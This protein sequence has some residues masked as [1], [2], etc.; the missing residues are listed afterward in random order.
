MTT[1]K[2]QSKTSPRAAAEGFKRA[3]QETRPNTSHHQHKTFQHEDVKQATMDKL[4][5][6]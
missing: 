4:L 5:N 2:T 6:P 1:A 3:Q